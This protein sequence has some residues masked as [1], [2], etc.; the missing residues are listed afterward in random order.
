MRA[1]DFLAANEGA[2]TMMSEHQKQTDFL[3]RC[4]LYDDTAESRKLAES[5]AHLQNSERRVQY[6]LRLMGAL[7]VLAVVG[8]CYSAIFLPY[9]PQN[10]LGFTTHFITQVFCVLGIVSMVCLLVFAYLGVV[11]RKNLDQLREECRQ[12]VAKC[13]ET[14]MGKSESILVPA[15]DSGVGDVNGGAVLKVAANSSPDETESTALG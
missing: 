2:S 6:G 12:S 4:L 1:P 3:K 13:M 5:I 7:A 11:Y 10:M 8:L 14:R 15:R 9:F